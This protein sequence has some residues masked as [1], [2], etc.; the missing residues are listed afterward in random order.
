[1]PGVFDQHT[2]RLSEA[3]LF[4]GAPQWEYT[5][6]WP[7]VY[8]I[9]ITKSFVWFSL[10]DRDAAFAIPKRVFT[11]DDAQVFFNTAVAYW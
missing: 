6:Y 9:I 8:D 5:M 2:V 7:Y 11:D 10:K 4:C 1:M 3:G